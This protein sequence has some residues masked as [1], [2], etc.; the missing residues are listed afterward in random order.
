MAISTLPHLTATRPRFAGHDLRGCPRL[1]FPAPVPV[2]SDGGNEVR[3]HRIDC[4]VPSE[5][6][7]IKLVLVFLF[8]RS[9]P[10]I[11]I[12]G[13][14]RFQ[15]LPINPG[16]ENRDLGRRFSAPRP[17]PRNAHRAAVS[18]GIISVN[19]SSDPRVRQPRLVVLTSSSL[20]REATTSFY[21]LKIYRREIFIQK[22]ANHESAG[23]V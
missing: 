15:S 14:H 20:L 9:A 17:P 7:K 18:S 5:Q 10:R 23:Q 12:P 13:S 6:F 21:H 3:C 1:H 4:S 16:D 8:R 22:T 11:P 2:L 19:F